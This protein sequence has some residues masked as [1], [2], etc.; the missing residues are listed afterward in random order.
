[1]ELIVDIILT[2]V[3]IILISGYAYWMLKLHADLKSGRRVRL[4][5]RDLSVLKKLYGIALV[6]YLAVVAY[7][8]LATLI[9]I[10]TG[11]QPEFLPTLERAV[12]S[13]WLGT[14]GVIGFGLL[15]LFRSP[16]RKT[17]LE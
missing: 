7:S 12:T 10:I 17:P 6:G 3:P 5:W 16:V 14:V 4:K 13:I 2:V 15:S 11:A 9:S 8:E 1:M